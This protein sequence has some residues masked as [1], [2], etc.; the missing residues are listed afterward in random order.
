MILTNN[1]DA[2]YDFL[3]EEIKGKEYKIFM[4]S[5]F[6]EDLQNESA[7]STIKDIIMCIELGYICIVQDLE[8]IY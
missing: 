4:G 6:S 8:H 1:F 5:D 3:I 7:Y 2:T